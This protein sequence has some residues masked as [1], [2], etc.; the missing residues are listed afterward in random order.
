MLLE[1]DEVFV[2]W[3]FRLAACSNDRVFLGLIR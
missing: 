1:G 2:Q 3:T